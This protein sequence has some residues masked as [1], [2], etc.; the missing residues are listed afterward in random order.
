MVV[1]SSLLAKIN[2][3]L[4]PISKLLS[5]GLK[6]QRETSRAPCIKHLN[7]K[8]YQLRLQSCWLW[9]WQVFPTSISDL[10]TYIPLTPKTL[11]YFWKCLCKQECKSQNSGLYSSNSDWIRPGSRKIPDNDVSDMPNRVKAF[12]TTLLVPGGATAAWRCSCFLL[13]ATQAVNKHHECA[14]KYPRQP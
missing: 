7:D 9:R 6:W 13:E 3:A 1:S 10:G 2:S 5:S 11:K 4:P 12:P 14:L 8:M